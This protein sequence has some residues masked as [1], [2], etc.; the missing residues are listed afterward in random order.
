MQQIGGHYQALLPLRLLVLI[1]LLTQRLGSLY[2]AITSKMAD[3]NNID[4]NNRK[5]KVKFCSIISSLIYDFKPKFQTIVYQKQN[6]LA[7]LFLSFQI[8]QYI[9]KM[10]I[11]KLWLLTWH[12]FLGH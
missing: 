9:G 1:L 5:G 11:L 7:L 3:I 12:D 10:S 4:I 6:N 8:W 2:I